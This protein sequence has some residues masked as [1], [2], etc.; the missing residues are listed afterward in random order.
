MENYKVYP[1]FDIHVVKAEGAYVWDD[2]GTKY[3]DMYGGHAVI[4]IG[5][6]HPKY[7]SN[8]TKQVQQIGFYSNSIKIPIQDELALELGELSGLPDYNLFLCNSGAEANE[9]ALKLA[10]FETGRKK[11]LGFKKGFHG[12]TSLA[13]AVTDNAKIQAPVNPTDH[14]D[15]FELND[16]DSV[17]EALK[18]KEYAAVIIE[19][20]QGIG[21]IY[22]P[23]N[24]FLIALEQ[25]CKK[26]GT[27]L[28]LDE[29]QSGYGRSGKFFAFQYAGIQ[30][31]LV[32]VAKGMGNG[33]PIGGVLIAPRFEATYGQLGT[34]F[35]GNH[36]A[37]A[38]ALAVLDVIKEEGLI[39]N[40]A[41]MGEYIKVQLEGIDAIKE[42]R[43]KG[44]LLGL[45]FDEPVKEIRS[46]LLTEY[47]IFTGAATSPN[48]LRLLPPMGI[49]KQEADTFV[50]ALKEILS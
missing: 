30:P 13:V 47:K 6:S 14:I 40:A 16:L 18:T 29:I 45:E 5:H 3:L 33:F 7:V 48:V 17:K 4:S 42:I 24:E 41:E 39:H 34:T 27:M 2:H 46:L 23:T 10:S 9:N 15:L 26:T 25:L 8:I 22:K 32:T 19:G 1:V 38:A 11:V 31:D 28:I 36:L 21:G 12:R 44:L 37:C 49:G 20:I 35:G 43:G 50:N